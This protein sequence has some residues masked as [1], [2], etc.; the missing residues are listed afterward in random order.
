MWSNMMKH[1]LWQNI[2]YKLLYHC[3]QQNN[4]HIRFNCIKE[5]RFQWLFWTTETETNTILSV[6]FYSRENDPSMKINII[7]VFTILNN[8]ADA[9]LSWSYSASEWSCLF[10]VILHAYF[11]SDIVVRCFAVPRCVIFRWRGIFE[12]FLRKRKVSGNFLIVF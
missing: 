8:P 2:Q 3:L 6:L 12:L 1:R 7:F 10:I 4:I 5:I 11:E 9:W